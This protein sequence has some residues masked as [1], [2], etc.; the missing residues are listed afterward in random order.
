MTRAEVASSEGRGAGEAGHPE[1]EW[2]RTRGERVTGWGRQAVTVEGSPLSL[3]LYFPPEEQC[4]LGG[5]FIPLCPTR[6]L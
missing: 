5:F 6:I 4:R 1:V 2:P 3:S